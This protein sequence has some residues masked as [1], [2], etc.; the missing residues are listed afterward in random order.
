M[1]LMAP[2]TL[3]ILS[4]KNGEKRQLYDDRYQVQHPLMN[5]DG[6]SCFHNLRIST[7]FKYDE[8]AYKYGVPNCK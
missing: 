3:T 8:K 2:A 7:V 4:A 6:F 1:L 5:P